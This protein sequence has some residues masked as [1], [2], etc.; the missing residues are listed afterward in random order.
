MAY[1]AEQRPNVK[2]LIRAIIAERGVLSS[3]DVQK[4]AGITRQA[5]H[6]HLRAMV[7]AGEIH[8]VGSGR[9]ARYQLPQR[10]T[11]RRSLQGLE[12]HLLWNEIFQADERLRGSPD[13]VVAILRFAFTEMVNNAIDHSRGRFVE[14]SRAW[15][16]GRVHMSV[17]DDGVGAF[18]TVRAKFAL[19]D[20]FAALQ[21]ISKGKLTTDPERHSG[22]GIFFTSKAVDRFVLEANALRWRVDNISADQAVGDAP[23]IRGTRVSWDLD[24]ASPRR[25][26]DVFSAFTDPET[27]DFNRSQAVVRLF[28][29]AKSFVSRSE[30]RRLAH[31]LERFQEVMVDFAGTSDVG[32]GFVDELFRVWANAHPET[33]LVPTNMSPAVEAMVRRGL[34]PRG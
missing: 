15:T 17:T 1:G 20:D 19:P 14:V 24:S 16:N 33:R 27:Y 31:G 18:Q 21:E 5:A 8:R 3:A 29:S 34:S 11:I 26:S 23:S 12:E 30:A 32:Q 25:L 2:D 9:G 22:E 10:R 7:Q 28:A 4:T 6:H 13:E